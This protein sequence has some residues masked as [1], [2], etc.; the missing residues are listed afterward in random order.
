MIGVYGN[1][2][3][4]GRRLGGMA[5]GSEEDALRTP[6]IEEFISRAGIKMLKDKAI[7]INGGEIIL[8]G[9]KDVVR[10]GD[11]TEQM[12]PEELI[13]DIPKDAPIILLQ[14]EPTDY[15]ELAECGADLLLAGHTHAGQIFP[16]TI[17]MR[18]LF[19]HFYGRR[20]VGESATAIVS[21]GVGTWG[22]PI[23]VGTHSLP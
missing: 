11:D 4:A 23:R 20:E 21:Q 17:L 15:E 1:H 9:R 16:G 19:S 10:P 13:A 2:D 12:M 8:V 14:H 6:E 7:A 22:P 5:I 3:V 18:P